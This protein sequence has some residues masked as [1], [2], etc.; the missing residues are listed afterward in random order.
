V[1]AQAPNDATVGPPYLPI[2]ASVTTLLAWAGPKVGGCGV[3]S[4]V[5]SRTTTVLESGVDLD[6]LVAE[7]PSRA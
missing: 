6:E 7:G 3:G 2:T 4:A 5:P 1:S